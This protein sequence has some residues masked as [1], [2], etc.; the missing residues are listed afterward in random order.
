M[1]IGAGMGSAIGAGIDALIWKR[2]R[3]YAAPGG[4]PVRV[5][6]FPIAGKRTT[7]MRLTMIF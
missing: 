1:M 5:V 7:G 4:T 2:K 6:L 3:V